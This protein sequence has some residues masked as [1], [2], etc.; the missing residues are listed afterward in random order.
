MGEIRS[1]Y[2]RIL[3]ITGRIRPFMVGLGHVVFERNTDFLELN[4]ILINS[5]LS[6]TM[7][8]CQLYTILNE[9]D[10]SI[11]IFMNKRTII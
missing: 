4:L 6:L 5:N 7:S 2:D 9:H 1:V 3:L 11:L 10:I 8:Q